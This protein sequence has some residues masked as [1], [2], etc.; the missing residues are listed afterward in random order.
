ML[1]DP[2]TYSNPSEFNPERFLA[3]DG[4]EPEADPRRACFGF[5]RRL[6]PGLHLADAS[7]WICAAMSL[8]VFDVSKVV[9]NGVEI[10]PEIDPS[11]G[12]IS[13]PKPFE[14]LIKA[15]SEKALALIQEDTY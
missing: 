6:C 9:E 5:G 10:T 3:K 12:S 4:K 7:I 1:N 2:Q 14:C 15:R 11:S 8:A 13:H